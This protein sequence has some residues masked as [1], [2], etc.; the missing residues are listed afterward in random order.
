M[1][2]VKLQARP[3]DRMTRIYTHLHAIRHEHDNTKAKELRILFGLER[4]DAE[5][6]VRGWAQENATG[7]PV[8]EPTVAL[9]EAPLRSGAPHQASTIA[10]ANNNQ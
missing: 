7:V 9:S 1:I 2:S 6:M 3:V 8:A 5:A 10:D 4:E